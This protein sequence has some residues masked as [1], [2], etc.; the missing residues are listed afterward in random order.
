VRTLTSLRARGVAATVVALDGAS[1]DD[2]GRGPR[3]GDPAADSAAQEQRALRFALAEY[4]VKT[5]E[6]HAGDNLGAVLA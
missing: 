5:Y 2:I 4:D 1:Y 6:V 3:G